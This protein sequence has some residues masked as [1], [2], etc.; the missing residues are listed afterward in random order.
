MTAT[1]PG[2]E[3]WG[4]ATGAY[5][6]GALDE[7]ERAGFEVHLAGCPACRLE[8]ATLRPAVEALPVSVDPVSPPSALRERI[9]AE[10]RREASLLAA[11]REP[12][13]AIDTGTR[14][15]RWRRARRGA[16]PGWPTV[17]VALATLLVGVVVGRG[18]TG[19][20]SRT[21]TASLDRAQ[22]PAAR[23]QLEV[24][25]GAATLVGRGMPAPPR[26]RVYQVWLKRPGR[27]PEPTATLFTPRRDGSATASVPGSLDGVEQ[28]LVSA[29]P[30]GGSRAPTSAPILSARTS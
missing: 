28:V 25:D 3:R 30:R 23:V 18:L 24:H 17:G 21:I 13:G 22:A 27:A 10:V 1:G 16:V 26:G 5:L 4:D 29:E 19:D 12:R 11:A 9:M 6:L 8:V 2:H 20:G 14:P 15:S 7:A